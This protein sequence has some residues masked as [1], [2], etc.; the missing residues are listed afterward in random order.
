MITLTQ[1][2]Y[3]LLEETAN[4]VATEKNRLKLYQ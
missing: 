1:K 3:D 2:Q 4:H